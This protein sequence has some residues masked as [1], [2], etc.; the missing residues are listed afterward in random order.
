MKD[1]LIAIQTQ[2]SIQTN[3]VYK[4]KYIKQTKGSQQQIRAHTRDG[5]DSSELCQA[6]TNYLKVTQ[7]AFYLQLF[8]D[9]QSICNA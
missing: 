5:D 8:F 7:G 9:T 3:G 4:N 1:M 2:Y 6:Y